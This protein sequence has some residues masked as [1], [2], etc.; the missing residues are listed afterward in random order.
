MALSSSSKPALS[1]ITFLACCKLSGSHHSW[2]SLEDAK[3]HH[4]RGESKRIV[5][6][7]ESK[8]KVTEIWAH[9]WREKKRP[10]NCVES[11]NTKELLNHEHGSSALYTARQCM[12]QHTVLKQENP[13]HTTQTWRPEDQ[14]DPEQTQRPKHPNPDS[15][16][17]RTTHILNRQNSSTDIETL[18]IYTLKIPKNIE[19]TNN[20]HATQH[21]RNMRK[22]TK[23]QN[24]NHETDGDIATQMNLKTQIRMKMQLYTLE[25]NL[26]DHCDWWDHVHANELK[27]Q[28]TH[29]KD[30]WRDH[31]NHIFPHYGAEHKML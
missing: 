18:K 2:W 26:V 9:T 29:W 8:R 11:C 27:W 14:I 1:S 17:H 5:N 15:K 10:Y 23:S 12:Q 25:I 6:H 13:T 28:Q 31:K 20:R 19:N 21:D 22:K 4:G 7:C 24:K 16:K 30:Y 3:E